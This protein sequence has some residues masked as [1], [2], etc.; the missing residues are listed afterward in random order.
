MKLWGHIHSLIEIGIKLL[1]MGKQDIYIYIYK[2][3]FCKRFYCEPGLG[4]PVQ[5]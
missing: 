5:Y 1:H 3:D 2:V 4:V